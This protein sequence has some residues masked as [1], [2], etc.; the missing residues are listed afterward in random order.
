MRR[1]RY[2]RRLPRRCR[3][4][5]LSWR[6]RTCRWYLTPATSI[7][8][9][10]MAPRSTYARFSESLRLH[11]SEIRSVVDAPAAFVAGDLGI[12]AQRARADD[13]SGDHAA[14]RNRIG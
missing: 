1:V 9:A 14:R 5:L 12:G 13:S 10:S 3:W 7:S 6:E 8:P 4:T 2:S 11:T